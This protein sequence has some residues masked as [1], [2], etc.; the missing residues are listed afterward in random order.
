M[1]NNKETYEFY[2]KKLLANRWRDSE[3]WPSSSQ[4]QDRFFLLSQTKPHCSLLPKMAA[5][6]EI[7]HLSYIF[8]ASSFVLLSPY[9]KIAE[10]L[11][12][13]VMRSPFP[14]GM[15]TAVMGKP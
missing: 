12:S 1:K 2:R 8:T 15:Y 11:R 14:L 6:G 4:I 7:F 3:Q 5:P 13:L 10:R 9:Q